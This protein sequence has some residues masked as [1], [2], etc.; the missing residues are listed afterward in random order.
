MQKSMSNKLLNM[1]CGCIWQEAYI[2]G[3]LDLQFH[4]QWRPVEGLFFGH[5]FTFFSEFSY[6]SF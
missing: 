6:T 4:D 1:V 3:D 5:Y 2:L